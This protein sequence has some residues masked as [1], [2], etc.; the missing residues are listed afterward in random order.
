MFGFIFSLT[1]ML[2]N[3][4]IESGDGGF[5]HNETTS[6]ENKINN[7]N[8]LNIDQNKDPILEMKPILHS[9]PA[10]TAMRFNGKGNQ[11]WLK[12]EKK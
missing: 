10:E 1:M 9:S 12:S 8:F 2:G 4:L 11:E 3:T 6:K 5:G 7:T